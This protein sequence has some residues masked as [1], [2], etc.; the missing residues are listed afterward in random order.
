MSFAISSMSS[1]DWGVWARAAP[2]P[3]P[4]PLAG[5]CA[6]RAGGGV[7][8]GMHGTDGSVCASPNYARNKIPKQ[9]FK[10]ISTPDIGNSTAP[11]CGVRI[12]VR[13]SGSS[14]AAEAADWPERRESVLI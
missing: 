8:G 11:A 4:G 13:R 7:G 3:R 6:A 9:N 1:A 5:A 10:R 2:G 14:D 12:R